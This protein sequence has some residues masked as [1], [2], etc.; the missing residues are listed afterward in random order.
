MDEQN[1]SD[2]PFHALIIHQLPNKIAINGDIYIYVCV[3]F[4]ELHIS[5][6]VASIPI[7]SPLLGVAKLNPQRNLLHRPVD[8]HARHRHAEAHHEDLERYR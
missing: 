8:V 2:S 4:S 3:S 7:E 1:Q 6:S 5:Y